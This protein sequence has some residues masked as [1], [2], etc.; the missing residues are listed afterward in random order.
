MLKLTV[1]PEEYIQIGEDIKIVFVGGS[2]NNM[3]VLISAPKEYNIIRSS[4]I[5]Q[6]LKE[7]GKESEIKKYYSDPDLSWKYKNKTKKN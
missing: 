5:E 3:R 4:V 2:K 6:A 7:Q 1:S